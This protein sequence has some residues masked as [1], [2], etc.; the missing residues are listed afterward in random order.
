MWRSG[1]GFR[2]A[3]HTRGP[4]FPD[5]IP[6]QTVTI[7]PYKVLTVL[8]LI[9][10]RQLLPSNCELEGLM[11]PVH[12]VWESASPWLQ[13]K[14][15]FE[16]KQFLKRHYHH[17]CTPAVSSWTGYLDDISTYIT[18][19]DSTPTCT[20]TEEVLRKY[21]NLAALRVNYRHNRAFTEIKE[22]TGSS[23]TVPLE[24]VGPVGWTFRYMESWWRVR[25][26]PPQTREVYFCS[27][28]EI[29]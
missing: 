24:T 28:T 29:L 1:P 15:T 7:L 27:K 18:S 2:A 6:L 16:L 14:S 19:R 11:K 22:L 21:K 4:R 25:L 8:F 10:G 3:T 26:K 9:T 17:S 23:E 13:R 5:G 12:H 20:W